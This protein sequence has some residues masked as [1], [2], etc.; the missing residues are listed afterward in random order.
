M[1]RHLH[2]DPER[3]IT[4]S[5]GWQDMT[6][7][8]DK[9]LPVK[10]TPKKRKPFF[11]YFAAASCLSI[12]LLGYLQLQHGKQKSSSYNLNATKANT[13]N[14]TTATKIAPSVFTDAMAGAKHRQDLQY[15][16]ENKQAS[17]Y[18]GTHP[19]SSSNNRNGILMN[20]IS[21]N[22]IALQKNNNNNG[23]SIYPPAAENINS[24]PYGN[25]YTL[26]DKLKDA[27]RGEDPLRKDV[28][29]SNASDNS[30]KKRT[31]KASWEIAAGISLNAATGQHFNAQPY[32]VAEGKYNISSRF[33]L[34]AGIAAWSPVNSSS[35]GI[36]KTVYV[37]DT[38]NNFRSYNEVTRYTRFHYADIPVMAGFNINKRLSVQAGMQASLLL[39]QKHLKT[40]DG[41]DFQSNAQVLPYNPTT[42]GISNTTAFGTVTRRVDY[43][44]IG[45]LRYTID[46]FAFNLSY[47]QALKSPVHGEKVTSE[48]N[49]LVSLQ[50]LYRLKKK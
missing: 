36:N 31:Y 39:S 16:S 24:I 13:T 48:K 46:K 41:Y 19:R 18:T 9:H 10:E 34:L 5:E 42:L 43:R 12:L 35:S 8:L 44:L 32:P 37:N 30:K 15:L 11:Y 22:D 20:D 27:G 6:Q 45:G 7:L 4:A 50:V 33:Y 1:N 40:L 28:A 47:Q 49:K 29:N 38:A 21:A 26:F 2:N 3:D 14:T 23:I 17:V 25:G